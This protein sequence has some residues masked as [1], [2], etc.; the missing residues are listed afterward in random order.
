MADL[1][2]KW[3]TIPKAAPAP[4]KTGTNLQSAV[5]LHGVAAFCL[6]RSGLFEIASV[7]VRLDHVARRIVNANHCI[8][9]ID[10]RA[11]RNRLH[12]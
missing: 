10:C 7:P 11:S 2:R 12:S 3:L 8:Q 4:T 1:R 9:L 5:T 6:P